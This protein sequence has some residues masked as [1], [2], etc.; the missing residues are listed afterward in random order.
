MLYG[1][2]CF[3]VADCAGGLDVRHKSKKSP[4]DL[5]FRPLAE[6]GKTVGGAGFGDSQG[7][8]FGHAKIKVSVRLHRN[9]AGS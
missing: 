1:T 5:S 7:L 2:G 9:R 6:L 8:R 4:G 3:Q